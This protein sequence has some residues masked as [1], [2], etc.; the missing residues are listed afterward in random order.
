M[1]FNSNPVPVGGGS[2]T[3]LSDEEGKL[4]AAS[5]DLTI[6][7][8]VKF[9][10]QTYDSEAVPTLSAGQSGAIT[11]KQQNPPRLRFVYGS[12]ESLSSINTAFLGKTMTMTIDKDHSIA[13]EVLS[14]ERTLNLGSGYHAEEYAIKQHEHFASSYNLNGKNVSVY[15]PHES[16]G[17]YTDDEIDEKISDATGGTDGVASVKSFVLYQAPT[18][19]LDST[20]SA[21]TFRTMVD[22]INNPSE[23]RR[24][25]YRVPTALATLDGVG[26]ADGNYECA[27]IVHNG[28]TRKCLIL[29]MKESLDNFSNIRISVSSDP[30]EFP[31]PNKFGANEIKQYTATSG[32]GY[33]IQNL[34]S[35]TSSTHRGFVLFTDGD[36]KIYIYQTGTADE[37]L[38]WVNFDRIGGSNTIIQQGGGY[39]DAEIDAKDQAV[40]DASRFLLASWKGGDGDP[41]SANGGS[42]PVATKLEQQA[43]MPQMTEWILETERKV[44]VGKMM[45]LTLTD[46]KWWRDIP[47]EILVGGM[48][49]SSG[50]F[51]IHLH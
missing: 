16:V 3:G 40:K 41:F 29:T 38:G 8:E 21:V 31:A 45:R 7:R 32:P 46:L 22:I 44:L 17:G 42:L 25:T 20:I 11:L 51:R 4:L 6:E 10:G 50:E 15:I 19:P 26:I 35:Q 24:D 2:G 48:R 34:I 1:V 37:Y 18:I 28:A 14:H 9:I 30:L 23:A 43:T 27:D 33:S 39:T 36:K 5:A 12:G 49:H 13:L 47:S